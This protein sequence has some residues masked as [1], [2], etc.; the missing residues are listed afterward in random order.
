MSQ[1]EVSYS[2]T[3]LYP[4][5]DRKFSVIRGL[6][7]LRLIPRVRDAIVLY[8]GLEVGSRCGPLGTVHN[9]RLN[10]GGLLGDL[11]YIPTH[12]LA[13]QLMWDA[14]HRPGNVVFESDLEIDRESSAI[15]RVNM[16]RLGNTDD[17]KRGDYG[18]LG[19]VL[20]QV[21]EMRRRLDEGT[22]PFAERFASLSTS[23]AGIEAT[24][25]RV[26][27]GGS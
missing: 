23:L 14:E 17:N 12:V 20:D 25:E 15:L 4:S 7:I 11:H 5:V 3:G 9:L 18:T 21:R 19:A 13:E 22:E 1:L 26:I 16:V 2:S 8:G 24:L 6:R 27:G 10:R